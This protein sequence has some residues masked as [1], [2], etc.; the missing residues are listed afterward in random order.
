[1]VCITRIPLRQIVGHIACAR[2]VIG[3]AAEADFGHDN[4]CCLP[5]NAACWRCYWVTLKQWS[6]VVSYVHRRRLLIKKQ[7]S[8]DYIQ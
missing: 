6:V 2:E 1:M 7:M 3:N 5:L 4:L 8:C